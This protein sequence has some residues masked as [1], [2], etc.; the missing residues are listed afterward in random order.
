MIG[1]V[2]NVRPV[3]CPSTTLRV[4]PAKDWK[5]LAQM[6]EQ[7]REHHYG[8]ERAESEQEHAEGIVRK[9]PAGPGHLAQGRSGKPQLAERLRAETTAS[10][11]CIS[12]RRKWEVGPT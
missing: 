8:E 10:L 11:K 9:A 6:K 5:L 2:R 4:S 3:N 12:A 1:F 7:S